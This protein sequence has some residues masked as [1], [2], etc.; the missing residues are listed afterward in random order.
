MRLAML[1]IGCALA[2][3]LGVFCGMTFFKKIEEHV[4][5]PTIKQAETPVQQE[6]QKPRATVGGEGVHI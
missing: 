4:A 3:F 1:I 2:T 5:T 6:E